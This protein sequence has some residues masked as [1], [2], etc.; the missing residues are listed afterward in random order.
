MRSAFQVIKS[1][2]PSLNPETNLDY[3]S[4]LKA[5]FNSARGNAPEKVI[6]SPTI[7]SIYKYNYG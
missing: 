3:Q 5:I 6:D 1:R 4:W 2:F 7:R